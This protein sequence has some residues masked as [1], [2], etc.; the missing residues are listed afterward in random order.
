MP[1]SPEFIVPAEKEGQGLAGISACGC[2]T[3][4]LSVTK[5][6]GYPGTTEKNVRD[7]YADMAKS[8]REVRWMPVDEIR[9]RI[10]EHDDD[11]VATRA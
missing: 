6:D 7:F 2:V 11:C 5:H 1:R 10:F 8:G 9:A 4:A 3:A